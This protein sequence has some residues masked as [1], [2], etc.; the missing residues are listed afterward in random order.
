MEMMWAAGHTI[1]VIQ[2]MSIN[3]LSRARC[4]NCSEYLVHDYLKMKISDR[5]TSQKLATQESEVPLTII[6]V[7]IIISSSSISVRISSSSSSSSNS[8]SS[9]SSSSSILVSVLV[10]V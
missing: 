10:L 3:Q 6:I 9:S 7:I 2:N 4:H 8:S 5:P 1:F